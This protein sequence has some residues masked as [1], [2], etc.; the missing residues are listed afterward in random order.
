MLSH[1]LVVVNIRLRSTLKITDSSEDHGQGRRGSWTDQRE[2][3]Q[4]LEAPNGIFT[5]TDG[6]STG[7]EFDWKAFERLG[8]KIA[9][10]EG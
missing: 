10:F 3:R 8:T 1:S 6:V 2:F 9:T 4:P 7:V 5:L